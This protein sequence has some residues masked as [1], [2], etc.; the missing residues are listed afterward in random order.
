SSH[1]GIGAI[2]GAPFMLSTLAFLVVGLSAKGFH[3]RKQGTLLAIDATIFKRDVRFFLL[4][5]SL[6]AAISFFPWK[7][8]RYLVA[9]FLGAA[10]V[11]YVYF[12][13][14]DGKKLEENF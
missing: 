13:I 14:Q 1:V 5:F 12:T 11:A 4:V 2:L 9:L 7:G 6:A 8:L 10:Y 3:Q